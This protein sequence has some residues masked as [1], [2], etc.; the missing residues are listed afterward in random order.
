MVLGEEDREA[1]GN[2]VQFCA[3]VCSR[4]TQQAQ[5]PGILRLPVHQNLTRS[6]GKYELLLLGAPR[7]ASNSDDL[8]A[9]LNMTASRVRA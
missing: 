1:L 4:M 2:R 6:G 8:P 5:T 3:V 9:W 7:H